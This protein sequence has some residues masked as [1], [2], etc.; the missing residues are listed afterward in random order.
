[1]SI[2]DIFTFKKEGKKIFSIEF[3]KAILEEARRGVIKL[4][5]ENI[6]GE[7]KKKC[8]DAIVTSFI[9]SRIQTLGI[10]NKIILWIIDRIIEVVPTITQLV[11]EFLKEKVENL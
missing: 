11:Y 3:F 6:P 5:K 2:F 10:T 9:Y 4:A 1:M 7:E 8:V